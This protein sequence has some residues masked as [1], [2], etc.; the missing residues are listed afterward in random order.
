MPQNK[1][2][3]TNSQ[4]RFQFQRIQNSEILLE[5]TAAKRENV[6][7]YN[8][9]NH[10][11]DREHEIHVVL[12][13]KRNYTKNSPGEKESRKSTKNRHPNHPSICQNVKAIIRYLCKENDNVRKNTKQTNLDGEES[14]AIILSHCHHKEEAIIE[15]IS[16]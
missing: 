14:S 7:S 9:K 8:A 4:L 12:R 3:K 15:A 6:Q 1:I 10:Q 16:L 11:H 5:K 2:K 13:N